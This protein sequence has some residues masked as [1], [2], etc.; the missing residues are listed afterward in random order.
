MSG[1]YVRYNKLPAKWIGVFCAFIFLAIGLSISDIARAQTAYAIECQP[2]RVCREQET[3]LPLRALPRPYSHLYHSKDNDA[4]NILAENVKAF[5]PVYVFARE[6]LDL[7]DPAEPKGWYR[8]GPTVNQPLGWMQARDVMEWRQALVVSYTHPGVGDYARKPVLMFNTLEDL[9]AV[10]EAGDHDTQA[11]RF[12]ASIQDGQIPDEVVSMEPGN[13]VNIENEFYILPVLDYQVVDRFDDETRLLQIAAAVP[14]QRSDETSRTVLRD[15]GFQREATRE[16]GLRE[17]DA[18]NLSVDIVFVIDLTSSMGPFID[19][20][21][22]AVTNLADR[23]TES[24]DLQGAIR[25]GAVGYR[26]NVDLMPRLEFTARNFTPELVSDQEL[27]EIVANEL[28]EATE[29]SGP[30]A[31]DVFAG[32][33]L[34]L[35]DTRWNERSLRFMV[36]IGDASAH[37]SDHPHSTTGLNAEELRRLADEANVSFFAIHLLEERA[38]SDHPKA[39]TQFSTLASNPGTQQPALFQ[40]EI[41]ALSDYERVVGEIAGRISSAIDQARQQGRMSPEAVAAGRIDAG[42]LMDQPLTDSGVLMDQPPRRD[43]PDEL[44]DMPR[45]EVDETES[46]EGTRMIDQVISAALV[47]YLGGE[48]VRDITFWAMDRD[49]TDPIKQSL[50]VRVMISREELSDLILS[51]ERVVEAIAVAEFTQMQFFESLQ[52]IMAQVAKGQDINLDNAQRLAQTGLM[53]RWIESL[54]YR[55]TILDMSD[56]RF[57]TLTPDERSGLERSLKSKLQMYREI[58]ER[59]DAWRPLGDT[60]VDSNRELVYPLPLSYLP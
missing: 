54:P 21:R 38:R 3:L 16:V 15:E 56:A 40:L 44:L 1:Y 49:L 28:E 50:E 11:E 5:S 47:K 4:G 6:D 59:V 41:T 24:P 37:E 32:V 9:Q 58:T 12:Y 19:G 33:K 8:V 34:A 14:R 35:D 43:E 27:I 36:L 53:P 29:S 22:Q 42:V 30:Y 23:L 31:E 60:A 17:E 45:V 13:F 7:S 2:D 26:D 10:V 57:E 52:A 46:D 18:R 39:E 48:P 55:S 20:T 51:L 25:F